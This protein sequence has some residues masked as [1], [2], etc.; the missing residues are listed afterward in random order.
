MPR[1]NP[2]YKKLKNNIDKRVYSM[3]STLN[4]CCL[5]NILKKYRIKCILISLQRDIIGLQD[6]NNDILS[7][8]LYF[9]EL[10]DAI[11]KAQKMYNSYMMTISNL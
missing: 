4:H 6:Y 8:N 1:V 2:I 3:H 11:E 10:E 5:P 9:P 7:N